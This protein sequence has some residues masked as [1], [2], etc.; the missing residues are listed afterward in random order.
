MLVLGSIVIM[1]YKYSR[2]TN[3]MLIKKSYFV[4]TTPT[5]EVRSCIA[6]NTSEQGSYL[7][8]TTNP[9]RWWLFL[10][11]SFGGDGSGGA[12][13]NPPP[14][15]PEYSSCNPYQGLVESRIHKKGCLPLKLKK[16]QPFEHSDLNN[17]LLEKHHEREHL[18]S[19]FSFDCHFAT[20]D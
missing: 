8:K 18:L 6:L 3:E 20:E 10:V 7:A 4:D 19:K 11:I 5:I 13:S 12:H 1:L 9:N 14:P 15:K 2:C 16:W 17:D